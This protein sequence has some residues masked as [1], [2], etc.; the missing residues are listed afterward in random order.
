M[1]DEIIA[2]QISPLDVSLKMADTFIPGLMIFTGKFAEDNKEMMKQAGMSGLSTVDITIALMFVICFMN[3][4]EL[5]S[6]QFLEVF[7]NVMRM[8][9]DIADKAQQPPKSILEV[10]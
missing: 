6:E 10:N 3:R 7:K 9:K 5:Q 1:S 8:T 4:T 2:P